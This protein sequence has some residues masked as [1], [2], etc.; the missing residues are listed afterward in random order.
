MKDIAVEKLKRV[1]AI[2][3]INLDDGFS[4]SVDI[5]DNPF[6]GS[7]YYDQWHYYD[8]GCDKMWIYDFSYRPSLSEIMDVL[9]FKLNSLDL[10]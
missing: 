5:Y 1:Y 4:F 9:L 2:V 7:E 3:T 8:D 10:Y 6:F